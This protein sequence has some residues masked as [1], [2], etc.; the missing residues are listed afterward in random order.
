MKKALMALSLLLALTLCTGALASCGDEAENGSGTT[1][2]ASSQ[3]SLQDVYDRITKKVSF[4]A[5]TVLNDDYIESYYGL[6]D[7]DMA[8]KY[9]AAAEDALLADTIAIVKVADGV[10]ST[11]IEEVFQGVNEQKKLELES[12]NPEQYK[13]VEKAAIATVGDYV[14][15]IVSDDNDAVI[16]IIESALA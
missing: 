2:A 13:R 15:Y 4:P 11:E 14:V 9:F 6:T 16:R 10:S 12:Y 1:S 3:K 5:M 7:E 8:D